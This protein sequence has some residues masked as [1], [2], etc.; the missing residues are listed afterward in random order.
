[1]MNGRPATL[2]SQQQQPAAS[3]GSQKQPSSQPTS[4]QPK[5]SSIMC[6]KSTLDSKRTF[7]QR[8]YYIRIFERNGTALAKFPHSLTSSESR[9][10]SELAHV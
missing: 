3:Q 4:Q 5:S 2:S 6:I 9:G 8:V 10:G 1:M 7:A